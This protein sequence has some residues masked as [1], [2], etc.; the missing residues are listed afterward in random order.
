MAQGTPPPPP[1]PSANVVTVTTPYVPGFRI[2]RTLGV[3]WGLIVRSRGLG[4]NITAGFRSL[5]G[6]EITE[7]TQ[8]LDQTRHEALQR[9]QQH[10]LTLGGNAV[11][12]VGFASSELSEVM[13]EILAYGTAV[14]IEPEPAAPQPVS[15]R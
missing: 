11:I 15:L 12:G 4:R 13:T 10:A 7:Y 5:A 1:L 14:Q 2:V 3:T 8:L 6:G 9:L